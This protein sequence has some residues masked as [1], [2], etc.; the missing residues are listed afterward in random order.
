MSFRHEIARVAVEEALA[1]HRRLAL[2]RRALAALAA[3]A[4][5]DPA[6]LAHHAEAAGDAEAVQRYAPAAGERAADARVRSRG[7]RQ[8]ARALRH[9]GLPAD[10]RAELLERRSYECY[11][12]HDIPGAVDAR[13]RALDEH[14]A[15]GATRRQG[16]AHRWLVA[17]GLVREGDNAAAED[18]ARRAVELLERALEPGRELAMAYSNVAQLRMLA[19]DQPG[20]SAWGER[21][22]ELAERLGE[23]EIVVHA[24][25]NMGAAEMELPVRGGARPGPRRRRRR[26]AARPGRA[27]APRRVPGGARRI[28]RALRERGA[29]DVS[30]GPRAATR[31]NPAG[32]TGRARGRRA[33][34]RGAAQ[35]RDR[36]TALRVRE[37]RRPPRL[38]R[39]AQARGLHAQP[40]R[41]RG[42]AWASSKDRQSSRCRALGANVRLARAQINP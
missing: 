30:R 29:R 34:G 18:E 40:G 36:R 5:P 1:P 19:S 6:R 39:P 8:F 42:R 24:L 7:G 25:N 32:L 12:T 9:G 11:L 37:D 2:H 13:Q 20:A 16:D 27:A 35:R 28:A 33:R 23:T 21:A 41:C 14:R 31:E 22:L 38:G 26:P 10:R 17:P 3:A 15:A 4:R